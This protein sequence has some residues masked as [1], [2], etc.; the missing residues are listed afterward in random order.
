VH[1]R[2]VTSYC[3]LCSKESLSTL[4]H[5]F[6]LSRKAGT[7][8]GGWGLPGHLAAARLEHGLYWVGQFF[9]GCIA[10]QALKTL[11]SSH[12]GF[13]SG[14]KGCLGSELVVAK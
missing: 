5:R 2:L 7:G 12:R 14:R 4:E 13:I 9:P 3:A 1:A 6:C 10:K 8:G 11:H